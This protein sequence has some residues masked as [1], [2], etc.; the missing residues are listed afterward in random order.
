MPSVIA[1]WEQEHNM[2]WVDGAMVV[3]NE[4]ETAERCAEASGGRDG[5]VAAESSNVDPVD[6][7]GRQRSSYTMAAAHILSTSERS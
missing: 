6:N 1:A 3:R 2:H 7:V 4:F 5:V